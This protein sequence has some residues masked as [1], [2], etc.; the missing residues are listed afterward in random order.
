MAL[1]YAGWHDRPRADRGERSREEYARTPSHA[2]ARGSSFADEA[3]SA[4]RTSARNSSAA[5]RNSSA[6]SPFGRP[7]PPRPAAGDMTSA[8]PM[9]HMTSP[10]TMGH[11]RMMASRDRPNPTSATSS[12]QVRDPLPQQQRP[13]R[14]SGERVAGASA[15]RRPAGDRQEHARSLPNRS[16]SAASR[17]HLHEQGESRALSDDSSPLEHWY[18]GCKREFMS[19]DSDDET[20]GMVDQFKKGRIK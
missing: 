19:D 14:A 11:P 15:S 5:S 7:M 16:A 8:P 12:K 18:P 3:S 20:F 6:A 9:M 4:A 1:V 2:S 10:R 17:T 13:N